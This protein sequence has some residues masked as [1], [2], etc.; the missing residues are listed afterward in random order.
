[1]KKIILLLLLLVNASLL[2]SQD[3]YDSLLNELSTKYPQEKTYIQTDK[4][5][6]IPGETI[7]F[8]TYVRA[9]DPAMQISTSMYAELLNENG[10]V[11][12]RK[13]MPILFK[14]AA[15]SFQLPDTIKSSKLFIRAYTSWM[16]NFDSS[17]LY[18]KPVNILRPETAL[19]KDIPAYYTLT[20]FPEGGDL[21]NGIES[22]VAFKTNDQD[23]KPF[24]V[25][26]TVVDAQEK[27]LAEFSSIHNGMGY[28]TITPAEGQ[29]YKAIWKDATGKLHETALPPARSNAAVLSISGD[30]G[31]FRFTITRS[32]NA[33]DEMKEFI[34]IAQQQQHTVYAARINLKTK[35]TVTAPIPIDSL[36]DGIMQVTIFNKA[37]VPVA[38]RIVYVKSNDQ[39]F[40][41]DLHLIEKNMIKKGRN[42]IQVDVGGSLKSNLSIAVTDADLDIKPVA[43]ENIYSH[44]LL[45]SD[46]KGS[47]YNPA[48]YFS[49][50]ED[51]VMN[52]L[53]L[54]MMTNGWRRFNWQKLLAGNMPQIR[55]R[56]EAYLTIKGNMYGLNATQM[57]DKMITGFLQTS[58]QAESSLFTAPVDKDG[59]FQI[60]QLYFFD[61]V[62]VLY[63]INGDKDKRLTDMASFSFKNNLQ[64]PPP[65]NKGLLSLLSFAPQP[66]KALA[67]KTIDQGNAYKDLLSRQKIKVL[68][69]VNIV[70]KKKSDEEKLNQQ[71]TSGL[72]SSGNAR[73]FDLENDP[74]ALSAMS[75]LDYLRGKVAGLQISTG[76]MDGGSVSRRGS[77]TDVFLNEMPTDI[78]QVQNTPMSDIAM[79]KIFDPPFFG[80]F[81]GGAGGAIAVYTK[82]GGGRKSDA[83]GLNVA[84]VQGYSSI[85]EF[86]S[87]DYST[88][89]TTQPDYRTTLYWGPFL[90]MNPQNKRVT[91]PFYNNDNAKR[92][93][94]VIEG[95][96]ELGQ[97]TR[98]EKI[99]E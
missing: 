6:Y 34:V 45:S 84:T 53:D 82:K 71:Y 91:I 96:N 41:T 51:S 36:P 88:E 44:F 15:S 60:D 50:D 16:L 42:V 9:D 69:T 38:E 86:Y 61:T 1:M 21:V 66:P 27:V 25:K 24:T 33:S 3:Q 98:E 43:S 5:Y 92:I 32:A 67:A 97:L 57:K 14:G 4:A 95:I 73:V 76:G 29:S 81:G 64:A 79:I 63:Q 77:P 87:P 59:N 2:F 83:K 12:E 23:G 75:V 18:T 48:Y 58:K 11:L 20:L 47:I 72:F 26:G 78:L 93:R 39:Y 19:K 85:K 13:S 37:A 22:R 17:L 30:N 54:V 28:F 52:Q 31:S 70:S 10:T 74:F 40:V 94:V 99:F 7:W 49:S 90:L 56:P 89:A 65:V 46:L 62:K 68:E 8:K 55:Y 35:T 80:A